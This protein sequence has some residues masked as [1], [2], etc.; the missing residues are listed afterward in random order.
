MVMFR[1]CTFHLIVTS[2]VFTGRGRE[3]QGEA[4]RDRQ[5]MKRKAQ[6]QAQRQAQKER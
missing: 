3:R 6:R 5:G 4:G 1:P 2:F